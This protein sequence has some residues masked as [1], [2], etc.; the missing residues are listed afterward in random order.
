MKARKPIEK[1]SW[2]KHYSV[3]QVEQATVIARTTLI[4]AYGANSVCK[5]ES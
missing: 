3:S 1:H 2:R 4:I 5:V